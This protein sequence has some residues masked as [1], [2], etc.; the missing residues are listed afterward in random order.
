MNKR[1]SH[2]SE[3]RKA[4]VSVWLRSTNPWNCNNAANVTPT[5]ALNNNNAYNA[6]GVVPD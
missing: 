2:K 3:W 6:N 4:I 1:A 5:G